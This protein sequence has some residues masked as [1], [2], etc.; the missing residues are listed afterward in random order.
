MGIQ[1]ITAQTNVQVKLANGTTFT[2]GGAPV[3][4]SIDGT[5]DPFLESL[6]W[7]PRLLREKREKPEP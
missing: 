3:F 1:A 4:E 7:S 2:G 5:P 6:T